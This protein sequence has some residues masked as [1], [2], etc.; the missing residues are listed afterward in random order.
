MMKN[1]FARNKKNTVIPIEYDELSGFSDFTEKELFT[2]ST[3][4]KNF[5]DRH[6]KLGKIRFDNIKIS[7]DKIKR[8]YIIGNGCDYA[9]ALAAAYN[10][11]VLC[12][13]PSFAESIFEFTHSNP[14]LDKSTL[15]IIISSDKESED[16]KNAVS[17]LKNSS[18]KIIFVFSS[19]EEGQNVI[20]VGMTE[21]G[22]LPCPS[23]LLK[24]LALSM[25]MVYI[26]DKNKVITELYKTIS[27]NAF[28]SI[29]KRIDEVFTARDII[30]QAAKRIDAN[31]LVVSGINVDFAQS[32]YSALIMS[33]ATGEKIHPV[34]VNMLSGYKNVLA[35]TSCIELN[36]AL[37][38]EAAPDI[39]ILP[40]NIEMQ[41]IT[42]ISYGETIPLLN[43]IIS[44]AVI[45]LIAYYKLRES[46][47]DS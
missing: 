3:L 15:V 24:Y 46:E 2:Q 8:A 34:A 39:A 47:A 35:I 9:C 14:V 40:A 42:T 43:P 38:K 5:I 31:G 16:C 30:F 33:K 25:L 21:K 29:S 1:F 11:E 18:A 10:A 22:E 13:I 36:K 27:L 45:E 7:F 6:I 37:I 17:R 32:I 12:D 26:G 28:S 4:A 41:D 20:S 19:G 23:F 44:T